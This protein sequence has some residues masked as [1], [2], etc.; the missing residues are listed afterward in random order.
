MIGIKCVQGYMLRRVSSACEAKHLWLHNNTLNNE[1]VLL[2]IN[3]ALVD[4]LM[5]Q[6]VT[7]FHIFAHFKF[8]A[9]VWDGHHALHAE[10]VQQSVKVRV[11]ARLQLQVRHFPL[12]RLGMPNQYLKFQSNWNVCNYSRKFYIFW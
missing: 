9:L 1:C 4:R 10:V 6:S 7:A 11:L 3:V 12:L 5:S 8:V 2:T